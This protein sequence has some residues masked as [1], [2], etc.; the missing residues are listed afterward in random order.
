MKFR[1]SLWNVNN[2]N[3]RAGHLEILRKQD[4]HIVAIQEVSAAFNAALKASDVFEWS[5]FFRS[6]IDPPRR[7]KGD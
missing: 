3:L 6:P 2:R 5:V 4:F 1:F 7:T